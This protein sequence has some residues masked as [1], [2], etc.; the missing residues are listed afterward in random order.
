MDNVGY[1]FLTSHDVSFL[2][3]GKSPVFASSLHGKCRMEIG[4][5]IKG[6]VL[7]PSFCTLGLTRLFHIINWGRLR[8]TSD[9]FVVQHSGNT[10]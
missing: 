8:L 5:L 9:D 3:M 7:L 10:Y 1:H 2:R 6:C 4:V